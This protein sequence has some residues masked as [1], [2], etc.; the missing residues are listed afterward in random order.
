M[1]RLKVKVT[2]N[3]NVEIIFTHIFV[4][5][6]SISIKPRPK[7]SSV[8]LPFCICHQMHF[9]SRNSKFI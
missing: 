2:G 6:G 8:L 5:S 3:E 7:W 4:K 9:T 1:K